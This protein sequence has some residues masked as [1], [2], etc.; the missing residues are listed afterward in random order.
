MCMMTAAG[1]SAGDVSHARTGVPDQQGVRAFLQVHEHRQDRGVLRRD[2]GNE[3]PGN[4]TQQLPSHR[5]RHSGQDPGARPYT[6]SQPQE[7][8]TLCT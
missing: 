5:R 2:A 3:G 8:Q 7:P 1:V 4:A 6:P